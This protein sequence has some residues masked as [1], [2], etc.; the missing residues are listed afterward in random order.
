MD[1]DS[2]AEMK[3]QIGD[4]EFDLEQKILFRDGEEISAEPMSLEVL[5]YLIVNRERYTSLH[6][7]HENIWTGKVVS[8]TA[9]RNVIKKLRTVL[10]DTNLSEPAYIKSVTK[11][12]YK[13]ICLVQQ[14]AKCETKTQHSIT[15]DFPAQQSEIESLLDSAGG[16]AHTLP[17]HQGNQQKL[18]RLTLSLFAFAIAIAL[19]L[20][21]QTNGSLL[22]KIE[23]KVEF[24]ER[25]VETQFPGGKYGVTFLDSDERFVF[26]GHAM[27]NADSQLY[28]F[29]KNSGATVQLTQ[30]G[31]LITDMLYLPEHSA[32][33]YN[34]MVVGDAA[35]KMLTLD[36][37]KRVISEETLI[38][39]L[40]AVSRLSNGAQSDQILVPIMQ[41]S[42]NNVMLYEL[43]INTGSTKRLT[44]TVY[45]SQHDYLAALSPD[46]NLLALV[47]YQDQNNLLIIRDYLTQRQLH[48]IVLD[49]QLKNISWVDDDTLLLADADKLYKYNWSEG[50]QHIVLQQ[51]NSKLE[52]FTLSPGRQYALVVE[53]D[54]QNLQRTFI[55]RSFDA[56]ME[57]QTFF[58]VPD[59]V[60]SMYPAATKHRFFVTFKTANGLTPAIY[61][62]NSKE[63]SIIDHQLSFDELRI[64][65]ASWHGE[66][67]LLRADGRLLHIDLRTLH[68]HFLTD[69]S[70][71]FF[72]A[73]FSFNGDAVL[74]TEQV[75]GE[76]IVTRIALQN[77]SNRR[78]IAKG[79]KVA[80]EDSK[81]LILCDEQGRLYR[82]T[83]NNTTPFGNHHRLNLMSEFSLY[84]V[85]NKVMWTESDNIY[86]YLHFFDER[87]GE[88]HTQRFEYDDYLPIFYIS[89]DRQTLW[90][91]SQVSNSQLTRVSL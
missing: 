59:N 75:A 15:S 53:N 77:P 55:S 83:D 64:L 68:M 19:I 49:K 58:G 67:L 57:R 40:K 24:S 10:S 37:E 88:Q 16:T 66:Q 2:A 46:K 38:A 90:H 29:D 41:A 82:R 35:I 8:D 9:V 56:D 34:D 71:V 27:G 79:Y 85:D 12:G 11:K 52:N 50:E 36:A 18:T 87:S 73:N 61:N 32:I 81:G 3:Y 86:T 7:L 5:A 44:A 26:S 69:F 74:Y 47:R 91:K 76:W 13:L 89:P 23:S 21:T 4:F 43:N 78:E 14:V 72:S 62:S 25:H 31:R 65:T 60:I 28:Y 84:S 22:P 17:F 70:Q 39:N 51:P 80:F 6:D 33:V 45:D 54:K 1:L 42:D 30:N 20:F 63:V 48:N